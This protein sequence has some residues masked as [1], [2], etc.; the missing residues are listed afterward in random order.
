MRISRQKTEVARMRCAAKMPQKELADK[1]GVS[2][3]HLQQVE[4]GKRESRSLCDRA[5]RELGK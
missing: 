2:V 5:R 3:G 4:Y 1:L